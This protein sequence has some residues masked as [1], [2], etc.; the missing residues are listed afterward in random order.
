MGSSVITPTWT[1]EPKAVASDIVLCHIDDTDSGSDGNVSPTKK[2]VA[3]PMTS[4]EEA[5]KVLEIAAAAATTAA[6]TANNEK[7][8]KA[9]LSK[10]KSKLVKRSQSEKKER[11]ISKDQLDS[12]LSSPTSSVKSNDQTQLPPV[13]P[14]R[15]HLTKLDISGPILQPNFDVKATVNLL[16]VCRS[17]DATPTETE[18]KSTSSSSTAAAASNSPSSQHK[19]VKAPQPPPITPRKH[20]TKSPTTTRAGA[21]EPATTT[22]TASKKPSAKRPA[23]IASTRPS[24]PS[25]PPPR[26]PPQ[27]PNVG[28]SPTRSDTSS[29]A[30]LESASSQIRAPIMPTTTPSAEATVMATTSVKAAS[31]TTATMVTSPLTSPLSL[32]DFD[33]PLSSPIIARRSPDALSTASSS[34][35]DLMREILKDLDTEVKDE[36]STLMRK[37]NKNKKKIVD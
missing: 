1:A 5:D 2:S 18:P 23:S 25:A 13:R 16:P 30:S 26:P 22:T 36:V 9:S 7:G 35:G 27:R 21:G 15:A 8:A 31:A 17:V 34:D 19:K 32:D 37:K 10:L 28:G 11:R 4:P 12:G 20:A 33:T 24:R 29:L 3:A 6:A 14:D